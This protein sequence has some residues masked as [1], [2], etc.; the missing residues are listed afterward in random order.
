LDTTTGWLL[1][2]PLR[3]TE[4][5]TEVER[6]VHALRMGGLV[7]LPTETVYGLAADAANPHAVARVYAVKGRPA[8]HPLILHLAATARLETW[9]AT[10]PE[11]VHNLAAEL[12]PGPLTMVLPR[13]EQ[14]ADYVTGGQDTVAIRVPDHPVA[15]AVLTEFGGGVVA[16]S[17]N[18]FGHVSPT[19][20]EHAR[21]DLG[22]RLVAGLDVVI[23]GGPCQV[24]VESTILDCT[25]DHPVVLRPGTLNLARIEEAAGVPISKEP[26]RPIRVPGSLASHYAPQA[27]VQIVS[28]AADLVLGTSVTPEVGLLALAEVTTPAGVV[29]LAAPTEALEYARVLYAALREADALQLQRIVAI[30]PAGDDGAAV[31]VRDRLQRAAADRPA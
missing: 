30:P 5:V 9:A 8:D 21:Q 6:G 13:T 28:N 23:D 15:Q 4:K 14:V 22:D 7:V 18:R 10:I 16:P 12:W 20:A 25:G 3:N 24:G 27:Q 26:A 2:T 31:A 1:A 17:A 19:T 29:R 11:Y